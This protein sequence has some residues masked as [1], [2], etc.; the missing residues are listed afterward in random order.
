VKIIYTET[1]R[2]HVPE[3]D[4][5]EADKTLYEVPKRAE[6]I[7]RAL[8]DRGFRDIIE[9]TEYPLDSILVVHDP[10]Y[11]H[12]LENIYEAWVAASEPKEG[13]VTHTFAVR[14]LGR[15][16]KELARQVG[17]YCFDVA[18]P[19]VEGTYKAALSSAF[20]AL[21][22]ADLLISGEKA[23]Y[24]LCR[25]PGH[26][27]GSDIYGGYCYLN[28]AAIAATQLSRESKVAILDIDYHHGNGT[29]EVFYNSSRVLF[30]SIHADPNRAYP[31]FSGFPDENGVG[32]GIGFNYNFPLPEHTDE[33][34]YLKT[35]E[36]A[37]DV[38]GRFAPGF[39]VI[40]AGF[41]T[42]RG[43][44]LGDFDLT[45]DSF[46][47]VGER[48]AD[49]R[50]PTLIVHEGGYNIEHLGECTANLLGAFETR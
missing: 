9:P 6:V 41:D 1:H 22:G 37:L 40:S 36:E 10:D 12:Y 39:L 31:F 16:P 5:S 28:N 20:C 38:I 35:L 49:L 18:A 8:Q 24:A 45:L 29:Q 25:P 46:S 26:H 27:A 44:P 3:K 47:H 17:Y 42:F 4:L 50:I 48:I 32:A 33:G 14:N 43:D 2:L 15:K 13:V 11:L 7:L 19:I 34:E 23:A 30:A 21:T